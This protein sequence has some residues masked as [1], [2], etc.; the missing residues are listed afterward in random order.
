M[1]IFL[2]ESRCHMV[3]IE[4]QEYATAGAVVKHLIAVIIE[5]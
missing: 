3:E 2:Q 4:G 5:Q 1:H